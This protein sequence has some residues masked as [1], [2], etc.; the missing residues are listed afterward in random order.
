MKAAATLLAVLL[1]PLSAHAATWK[2][3]PAHS[4]LD[5]TGNYQGEAFHGRFKQ[6]DAAIRYDPRNL[7]LARFDVTVQLGSVDTQNPER[8]QTL[9]GNDFFAVS[10]FPTAHFTTTA[11]QRGA[12]GTVT[13]DGTLSLHG[14]EQPVTLSVAFKPHG[15]EAVLTV[16]TTLDRLAYK[17]GTASDWDGIG[18]RIRV[19]ARLRLRRVP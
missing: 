7:D 15:E 8:D 12:D 13:A 14:I 4:S 17:L 9:T 19:H 2:V 11:F 18:K 16:D 1:L 3:D 6:F 5:F 10:R